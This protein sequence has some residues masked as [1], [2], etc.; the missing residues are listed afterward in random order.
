MS[1]LTACLTCR[2]IT[3]KPGAF[4]LRRPIAALHPEEATFRLYPEIRRAT[5]ANAF[6]LEIE[7]EDGSH[8]VVWD[9]GEELLLVEA[10]RSELASRIELWP[11][12]RRGQYAIHVYI[13][14]AQQWTRVLYFG[15]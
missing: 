5:G 2:G 1:Q 12:L 7:V 8:K 6:S 13:N 4:T 15:V 3:G 14:G 11:E 10:D 9:T